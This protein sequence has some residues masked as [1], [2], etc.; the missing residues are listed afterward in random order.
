MLKLVHDA[1]ATAVD[2][3]EA[4]T[5]GLDELCR[6]AAQEMLAVA[7]A[8]R[9]PGLPRGPRRRARRRRASAWWSATATPRRGR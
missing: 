9:A 1:T 8:G 5:I 4:M 3:P 6:V 2:D 7:L